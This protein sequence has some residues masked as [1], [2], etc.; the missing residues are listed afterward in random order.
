[1]NFDKEY[2]SRIFF[3]FFFF[4]GGGGGGWGVQVT[5]G[6]RVTN[7]QTQ[8]PWEYRTHYQDLFVIT[9]KYYDTIPQGMQVIEWTWNYIWNH[10]GKITHKV[11]RWELSFLYPTHHQDVFYITVKYHDN[12][13]KDFQVMERTRNCIW[14]SQGKI[15]QKGESMKARVAILVRHT[16]SWPVLH[17]CE[18]SWLYSKGYSVKE[19]TRICIKKH[20][21]GDNSN[22]IKARALIFVRD[23]RHD[24]VY[25][26]VKY[27]QN[28]PNSF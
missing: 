13:P 24:L 10:Q 26:T 6:G 7:L 8:E 25:I 17:N 5:G 18:V 19:G 3:F 28:I 21:R 27:H 15:T 22:S 1:M 20:L 11:C 12:K 9:V 4:G 23:N 16:S 2:K 14:N